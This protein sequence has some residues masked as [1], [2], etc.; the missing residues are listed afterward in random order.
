MVRIKTP[1]AS[2]G[3]RTSEEGPRLRSE[4]KVTNTPLGTRLDK[5]FPTT[6]CSNHTQIPFLTM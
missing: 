5:A 4:K 3:A 6:C 1:R 2:T